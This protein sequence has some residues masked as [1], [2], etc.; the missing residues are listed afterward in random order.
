LKFFKRNLLCAAGIPLNIS[1]S[2][3]DLFYF[4]WLQ[5]SGCS[6]PTDSGWY[7]TE[8]YWN[9]YCFV[10]EVKKQ[11]ADGSKWAEGY[12]DEDE[13]SVTQVRQLESNASLF[14]CKGSFLRIH[15]LLMPIQLLCV[16][17]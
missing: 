16:T 11:V 3:H 15:V 12:K 10:V 17:I 1:L 7:C 4:G 2:L 5:S 9:V 13:N 14:S 6:V 8:C